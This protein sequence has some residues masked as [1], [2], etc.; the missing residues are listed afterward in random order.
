MSSEVTALRVITMIA[1]RQSVS[2]S[3]QSGLM[4]S[5]G[6]GQEVPR[7]GDFRTA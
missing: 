5:A 1:S 3:F 6:I 7:V 4:A 2:P